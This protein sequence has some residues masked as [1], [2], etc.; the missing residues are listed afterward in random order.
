MLPT[1]ICDNA[2]EMILGE[3]KRK[4]KE[5][6]CH[7]KQT[8]PFTPW[9]NEAKRQIKELKKGSGKKFIKSG[10]PKTLG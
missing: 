6:S 9:S 5:V 10:A 2:K 8:E 4:L 1:V 7:L 3:F